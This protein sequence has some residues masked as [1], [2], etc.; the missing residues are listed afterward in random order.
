MKK[1]TSKYIEDFFE[2]HFID[3]EELFDLLKGR[4]GELSFEQTDQK[5]AFLT[6]KL[7]LHEE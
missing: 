7:K 2:E 6:I 3:D 1:L 5:Q 4:T